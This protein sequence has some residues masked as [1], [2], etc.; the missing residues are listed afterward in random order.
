M[1]NRILSLTQNI[2]SVRRHLSEQLPR[3]LNDDGKERLRAILSD[4]T[5][6]F[7]P[8]RVKVETVYANPQ[9]TDE[10]KL[11]DIMKIG[12]AIVDNFKHQGVVQDQ[13]NEAIARIKAILYAALTEPPKGDPVV[14]F[15]SDQELRQ[16]IGKR[17][18]DAA[19][20]EAVNVGDTDT[21]RALLSASGPQWVSAEAQRR[22]RDAYAQ[23]TNPDLVERL[24][25]TEV[26]RDT[27]AMLASAV[28]KWLLVLGASPESI[29]AATGVL[30]PTSKVLSMGQY[31]KQ[32]SGT[33]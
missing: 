12:P 21:T 3:G 15:L 33:A 18:A 27:L 20:L 22:G 31:A 26:L 32:L 10:G 19:F 23:R 16:T 5:E 29:Q 11:A 1:D 7:T 17:G 6:R 4:F 24:Q 13:A 2:E 25:Q 8:V 28:A 30:L 9:L 14:L